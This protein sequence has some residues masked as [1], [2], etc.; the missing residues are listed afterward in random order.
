MI[1]IG[2]KK[3][4]SAVMLAAVV[5]N[6]P[7][8][9][10]ALNVSYSG[11]TNEKSESYSKFSV[12]APKFKISEE[13]DGNTSLEIVPSYG[14]IKSAQRLSLPEKYDMRGDYGITSVKNQGSYGTCWSHSAIASAETSIYRYAPLVDLSEF[15]TAFYSYY[16]DDQIPTDSSTEE[17]FSNGG[18]DYI[19]ANLWSQ[20]IG[21]VSEKKLRYGNMSFFD[22]TTA[23][24]K[25]KY[26]SDYHMKNAYMFDYS[27]DRS[28][29]DDVNIII[30]QF[31]YDGLAVDVSFQ[32]DTGN[33]YSAE[34]Y[35]SRSERKPRFASHSVAIVGWDDSFPKE[36][37]KKQAEIDGAWLVKNSWGDQ[38]FDGGYMWISYDDRSLCEFAVFELEDS[39][40]HTVNYHHDTYV[41]LQ[42]MSAS[43]SA[44]ENA[45]SYMASVFTAEEDFQ[46]E[47]VMLNFPQPYTDYVITIYSGLSDI[48]DPVSGTASSYT[49][50]RA[51]ISGTLTV[52][53]DENVKIKVG[54]SFSVV[55]EMYCPYSPFVI[56]IESALYLRDPRTKKIKSLGSLTDYE[57]I[58]AN[59]GANE[60]FYSADGVEWHDMSDDDYTYSAEE[61]EM[62]LEQ[63]EYELFDGIY[64]DE[65]EL[66]ENAQS[67]FDSYK[68]AFASADLSITIGNIPLKV[69]GNNVNDVDFSHISGIVP[70]GEAVE[71]SV[72]DGE[73]VYYS[74][75]GGEYIPYTA[76]IEIIGYDVISATVDFEHYTERSYIS[77]VSDI[78][79]GDADLNGMI[80]S[81]DASLVLTHYANVL[82]GKK[83]LFK[84][85]IFDYADFNGDGLIDSS[86]ASGI[87]ELY[88]ERSTK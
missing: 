2:R 86:D 13:A 57:G 3:I 38:N 64:P 82:T 65:T 7:M 8:T 85:A 79:I 26:D 31:V 84:K 59:T 15:H 54:E 6:V 43:D 61:K 20:W 11:D 55:A 39:Q 45:P 53:L 67:L 19:V 9:S 70:V 74:V 4:I 30:K 36:N 63:L 29:I 14:G 56:P 46:A 75:N 22:N 66:L 28:D 51:D 21:P 73:Q 80:D 49:I 83:P 88:A 16:G 60:S 18:N 23:V 87:L 33:N 78:E 62:L 50:G 41:P 27:D 69:L 81:S 58:K 25:L 24:D 32:P 71:L 5:C 35:S 40:E 47:A 12:S 48:S 72:K 10:S 77:G 68:A 17:L 34:Y 1:I 52:E 44:D 42:S 37:F 76:P